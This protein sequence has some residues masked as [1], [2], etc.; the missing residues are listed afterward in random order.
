MDTVLSIVLVPAPV[1]AEV[2]MGDGGVL[3]PNA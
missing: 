2:D 3:V 1:D